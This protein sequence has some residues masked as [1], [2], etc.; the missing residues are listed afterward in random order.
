MAKVRGKHTKPE[1]FV[2]KL[3]TS[4]GFRYR[5][6]AANLPGKPDLVFPKQKK[7]IFVH[8]CFWHAHGCGLDRAPKSRRDFWGPK[9]RGNKERDVLQRKL[10]RAQGWRALVLWECELPKENLGRRIVRFLVEK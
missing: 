4:L 5:L 3:V 10:L 8:G 2:R 9:L 1:L 6:H 7:C